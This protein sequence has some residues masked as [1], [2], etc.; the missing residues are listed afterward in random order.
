MHICVCM[1]SIFGLCKW[2][3]ESPALIDMSP[4]SQVNRWVRP[5]TARGA[6]THLRAL[7]VLSHPHPMPIFPFHS[8]A[9]SSPFLKSSGP[10]QSCAFTL[11]VKLSHTEDHSVA[12]LSYDVCPQM[13][14]SLP[15]IW[16]LHGYSVNSI[17]PKQTLLSRSLYSSLSFVCS[18][19]HGV[20]GTHNA[21]IQCLRP[22]YS[23]VTLCKP[24]GVLRCRN[25]TFIGVWKHGLMRTMKL[26]KI[27]LH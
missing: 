5:F 17:N 24:D 7:W 22:I 19:P 4:L 23:S 1:C 10:C 6:H 27:M 12:T 26:L 14:E 3:Y 9:H 8:G 25:L 2:G 21:L 13:A 18:D 16:H 15:F 20:H 11:R